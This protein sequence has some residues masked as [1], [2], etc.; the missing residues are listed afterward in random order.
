MPGKFTGLGIVDSVDKV[1]GFDVILVVQDFCEEG[2]DTWVEAVK[3]VDD[4]VARPVFVWILGEIESVLLEWVLVMLDGL[5]CEVLL[6]WD[7]KLVLLG[8]PLIVVDRLAWEVSIDVVKLVSK[9]TYEVIRHLR[10]LRPRQSVVIKNG[11]LVPWGVIVAM[12]FKPRANGFRHENA[13]DYLW[14]L[15]RN[16]EAAK[17]HKR[18]ASFP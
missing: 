12:T 16:G 10:A 2:V 15:S 4:I 13:V 11:Y 5:V 6:A 18:S 14:I 1:T 17:R 3:I 9:T 8:W 7:V